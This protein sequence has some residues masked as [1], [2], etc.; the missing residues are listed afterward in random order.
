MKKYKK[1][2]T[3]GVLAAA[4][5]TS[6]LSVPTNHVA[7][8]AATPQPTDAQ[9]KVGEILSVGKIQ[10]TGK[11]GVDINLPI[12]TSSVL[13]AGTASADVAIQ[14]LDPNNKALT[15][16][17]AGQTDPGTGAPIVYDVIYTPGVGYK[18]TPTKVGQYKIT[19]TATTAEATTTSETYYILVSSDNYSMNLKVND[20]VILPSYVDTNATRGVKDILIPQPDVYNEQGVLIFTNGAYNP[21][22]DDPEFNELTAE[23]I[24]WYK[25]C[26]IDI[27]V[28]T[29]K[30]N[31]VLSTVDSTL[32]QD[33]T[34]GLY[35][36]TP[37]E[38]TN[39][40][41]Y[42]LMHDGVSLEKLT[43]SV[44][45]S[46]S[47]NKNEIEVRYTIPNATT[48]ASLNDRAPLPLAE[49]YNKNDSNNS[50]NVYTQVKVEYRDGSNLVNVPVKSDA[51][52]L[53]FIPE[54]EG[55]YKITYNVTDFY[56][57]KGEEYS[58][59]IEGVKDTVAPKL[60][61]VKGYS[62][63]DGQ[64]SAVMVDMHSAK[65]MVPNKVGKN[66][67][68][69][70]FPAMYTTDSV[71][72]DLNDSRFTFYRS[73]TSTLLKSPINLQSDSY[74]DAD[75]DS[76]T[77][78]FTAAEKAAREAVVELEDLEPGDYTVTYR[79]SDGSGYSSSWSTTFTLYEELIDN[80]AP[81]IQ[82]GANFPTLVYENSVVKFVKPTIS[83]NT[84]KEI[85]KRYYVEF[86]GMDKLYEIEEDKTD[87]T[88][89]SFD[90]SA[91]VDLGSGVTKTLYQ[92]ALDNNDKV[93]VTTYVEDAYNNTAKLS[94]TINVVDTTDNSIPTIIDIDDAA[95]NNS[96]AQYSTVK[97]NGV[98]FQ[99]NDANL[100][101][102]VTIRDSQGNI[103][104]GYNTLGEINRVESSPIWTHVHPGVSFL[105][106]KAESYTV[107]YSAVD[108]GNNSS[109][110]TVVLPA[111]TDKEAPKV[112][113]VVNNKTYTM[114]LGERLDLG[115]A[116]V[117]DNLEASAENPLTLTVT[118]LEEPTYLTNNSIF[119]PLRKGEY[120]IVYKATDGQNNTSEEVRV[121][122]IV[123]DTTSPILIV[124]NGYGYQKEITSDP[125]GQPKDDQ[126]N[127]LPFTT[128]KLP[129]FTSYDDDHGFGIAS[130]SLNMGVTA[131]LV[132]VGPDGKQYTVDNES[133]KY[134]LKLD[135]DSYTFVPTV[136]GTYT[137][138]YS[139]VDYSGNKAENEVIKIYVGDTVKPTVEY[140][141]KINKR[142]SLKDGKFVLDLTKIN[143]T[144][145][146]ADKPEE[147]TWNSISFVDKAGNA[148]NYKES[149][150]KN[151]R[152]YTFETAGVYTLTI[153]AKDEAGNTDVYTLEV[154]VVGEDAETEYTEE[155]T[156]VILIV[157][158]LVILAGVI[159]YFTKGKLKRRKGKK[160]K[161]STKKVE[162]K[163]ES[164]EEK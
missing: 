27:T 111:L 83:D 73:I 131:K 49:A 14:V 32:P 158:S 91:K 89:L 130:G 134:K 105:A 37:L 114:Q 116:E 156:G 54:T 160:S 140:T 97:V 34:S 88:Y 72:K 12:A 161:K 149:D 162:E 25:D 106:N 151:I 96:Y 163:T 9:I 148:V 58:Y 46:N 33:T 64:T 68:S 86:D 87:P 5:A 136:K 48:T 109:S 133:D 35:K 95:T 137:A 115:L 11:I 26:T 7:T 85:S 44:I 139:S 119:A 47:Y 16:G 50:I 45:G 28:E 113:G 164:K 56:G 3:S 59:T 112:T 51:E 36:F 24:A 80:A 76:T 84:A 55:N 38:G 104:T 129:N 141:G 127:K 2:L 120:T 118:C 77:N 61:V 52:G 122:V 152:T 63:T 154:T 10:S 53:Y 128:I 75:G 40:I 102:I 144:D 41:N 100:R 123:E 82:Y 90:M 42:T 125:S 121:K 1:Y 15:V 145:A 23:Q 66:K 146:Q 8:Y 132:V 157:V 13:G 99:D 126:G 93:K 107:T 70:T 78:D 29:P 21:A 110:I 74:H 98:T 147:L 135:G 153:G 30:E 20:S 124:G 117:K 103:V 57:N 65:Y 67:V 108:S 60:F 31:G 79:V 94:K 62:Y 4:M 6:M 22:F 155:V 39:V 43:R 138:T 92:L 19:Y 143:V 17:E 101:I 71:V 81:T 69:I 142:I 18:F 159:L 150:D